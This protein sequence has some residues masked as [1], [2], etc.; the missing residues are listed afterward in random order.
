VEPERT[1]VTLTGS[2]HLP[3]SRHYQLHLD[4]IGHQDSK[5]FLVGTLLHTAIGG[6][7][8]RVRAHCPVTQATPR[9][10]IRNSEDY[11]LAPGA[12]AALGVQSW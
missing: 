6:R 9:A 10:P 5:H 1:T 7:G 11:K 3:T 4:P 2:P 12:L 8:S